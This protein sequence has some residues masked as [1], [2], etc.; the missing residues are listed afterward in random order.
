MQLAIALPQLG[1]ASSADSIMATAR[2]AE[3]LGYSD[4]WANDHIGFAPSTEHPSPRMH[5][6]LLCLATAAAVTSRIGLGSHINAAYYPPIWLAR[7]LASLDSLSGAR[8]KVAIG[9]GWQPEEFAAMG[10]DFTTRGRRTDE[11]I[12]IL[13]S[14]W[15]T[16]SSAF[17]GEHYS[18][19][20]LRIA[21]PPPVRSIPVWI[22]GSS[23]AALD[24]AARLGNGY[25]GLPTRREPVTYGLQ[26][27][28]SQLPD[29]VR[30]LR[31]RRPDPDDF[32][33]SMYTHDWDP[34][35][36]DAD[37]IRREWH[38][39]EAAGVQHVVAALARR[40]GA[41]WLQSLEELANI[42]GLSSITPSAG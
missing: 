21:P 37:L 29:L 17:D 4:L 22:A 35:E 25:Q 5:D 27:G 38:A 11:I 42:V 1:R 14:A 20:D 24:R 28:V 39:Y 12:A 15:E 31:K 26:T 16:G 41:A 6:P 33:I 32:T 34:A 10:S 40:D 30:R 7:A 23:P 9:V 8:L 18:F 36:S 13:R 3:E 19:P 2:R